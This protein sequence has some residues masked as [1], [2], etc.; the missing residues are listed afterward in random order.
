MKNILLIVFLATISFANFSFTNTADTEDQ[1]FN[2]SLKLTVLDE[3]GNPV[4][5][6]T[7]KVYENEEDYKASE[8]HIK[9]VY[10][11]D[12]KGRVTI[13][14]L[15]ADKYFVNVEKGDLNNYMT[16]NIVGPLENAKLNKANIIIN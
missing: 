6:A 12:K 9:E 8:N 13:K 14:D 7:V 2:T 1:I 5:G 4:E 3:M 15:D 16:G 10:K 11:T